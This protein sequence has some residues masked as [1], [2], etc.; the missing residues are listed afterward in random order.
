MLKSLK[1]LS[2]FTA[3]AL[4]GIG[5]GS[6]LFVSAQTVTPTITSIAADNG[7]VYG[8]AD[9]KVYTY[10]KT[11][12]TWSPY[13]TVPPIVTPPV[14]PPTIPPVVPPTSQTGKGAIAVAGLEFAESK[15]PGIANQDY[16]TNNQQVYT[17]LAS[18]GFTSARIPFLSGR[19][20]NTNG[21]INETYAGYVEQNINYAKNAG[22]TAWID[23]HDY[24]RYRGQALGS[25][26]Y[27]QTEF[28]RQKVAIISRFKANTNL[29]GFEI[30]NEPHDLTIGL[31]GWYGAASQAFWAIQ[32]TGWTGIV[33]IP[34]YNWSSNDDFFNIH[35]NNFVAPIKHERAVYVFHNYFNQGNSGYNHP[36]SPNETAQIHVDRAKAVL[37]WATAQGVKT[38]W[39]EYGFPTKA[40]FNG[41]AWNTNAK[42]FID[43]L[44][45]STNVVYRVYWASGNWYQSDTV[46]TDKALQVL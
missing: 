9:S 8:L 42:P 40:G 16:S 18:K 7:T 10:N 5:I 35:G 31:T 22:M 37:D 46:L 32:N 15:L 41:D 20:F 14:I 34:T 28:V 13:L 43:L 3:V 17:D 11:G 1:K 45:S 39:T 30:D 24:A 4:L 25:G 29:K 26:G 6:Q 23:A 19:F 27:S 21:T 33:G 12:G 2:M 38:A 36:N 44:K